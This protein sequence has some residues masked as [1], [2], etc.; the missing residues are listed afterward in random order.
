MWKHMRQCSI[1]T[2]EVKLVNLCNVY[3]IICIS[4]DMYILYVT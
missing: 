4:V 3:Q 1:E 2:N